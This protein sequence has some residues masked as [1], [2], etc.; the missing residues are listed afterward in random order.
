MLQ[1]CT[2]VINII[3]SFS[4]LKMRYKWSMTNT[5]FL[6]GEKEWGR[7]VRHYGV[8]NLDL[9]Q[10]LI[11]RDYDEQ[12]NIIRKPCHLWSGHLHEPLG[13]WSPWTMVHH[14]EIYPNC[15]KIPFREYRFLDFVES[16]S[17]RLNVSIKKGTKRQIEALIFLKKRKRIPFV[18][19]NKQ[20]RYR[21]LRDIMKY[22]RFGMLRAFVVF[23][24]Y[25]NRLRL[26]VK[27]LQF[28]T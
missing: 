6:I 1:L 18:V 4:G 17:T 7:Y 19:I 13:V 8:F 24:V 14:C 20:T 5:A 16:I 12:W 10:R 9:L 23:H 11:G 28:S 2:D 26:Y 3:I 15:M 22:E 21:K 27:R 25:Q